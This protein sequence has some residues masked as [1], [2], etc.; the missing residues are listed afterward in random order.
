MKKI[1]LTLSAFL[2]LISF[3]SCKDTNKTQD[4]TPVAEKPL[5]ELQPDATFDDV[6]TTFEALE[7]DPNYNSLLKLVNQAQM[8]DA[9]KGLSDVTFFAPTNAAINRLPE[10]TYDNLRLPQNLEKLQNILK[11]HIVQGETD[12]AT[13]LAT[14]KDMDTPYRLKTLTGGYISLRL[15]E[16]DII[17]TDEHGTESKVSEP[18]IE[19]SNGVIHGIENVLIP[20]TK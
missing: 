17:I 12:A 13:L 6:V 19:T 5:D 15:V 16:G 14:L 4:Q 10:G 9:V 2:M 20:I 18:D 7:Q 11:Y 1:I 3:N 8:I